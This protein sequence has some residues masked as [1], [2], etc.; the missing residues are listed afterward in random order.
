MNSNI[1]WLVVIPLIGAAVSAIVVRYKLLDRIV[2]FLTFATTLFVLFSVHVGDSY[3]WSFKFL[4]TTLNLTFGVSH[5]SIFMLY[6]S[7]VFGTV[8]TFYSLIDRSKM[9][10][11]LL[12]LILAANN[13]IFMANDMLGFFFAWELMGWSS[14][15]SVLGGRETENSRHSALYYA[16][17]SIAGSYSMLFGIFILWRLTGTF[18]IA[19]NV[20]YLS[21]TLGMHPWW[22]LGI[23]SLFFVTFM[24]K[25]GIFPFHTWVPLAY[26]YSPD[27]FT[28]FLS[29]VMSKYGVYGMLLF[30]PIS[31]M[32]KGFPSAFGGIPWAN[33]TFVWIGVVT[34]VVGTILAIFQDDVKKLLAYSSLSNLGY[35]VAAIAI[36]SPVGVTAG[37]YHA[38]NHLLFKG[39]LF[40][41][42][43]AVISRTGTSKMSEMG[44]LWKKMPITFFTFFIGIASAAGI[45]PFNGFGSKWMIYQAMIKQHLPFAIILLFLASTGA[46]MY[47]FKAFHSVFLGQLSHKYDNVKEVSVIG[48]IVEFFLMFAMIFFGVQPGYILK[49]IG[50]IVSSMGLKPLPVMANG[51]VTGMFSNVYV[52]LIGWSLAISFIFGFILFFVTAKHK[53]VPQENN[54]T[55]GQN[56]QDWGLTPET[57]QFSWNFYQPVEKLFAPFFKIKVDGFFRGVGDWTKATGSAIKEIFV[58]NAQMYTFFAVVGLIIF[59]IAGWVA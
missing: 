59:V 55:A 16:M 7:V 40:I 30:L 33:Y 56:P 36:F 23:V 6:I 50:A 14:V 10:G 8:L 13:W 34:A 47:L 29:G 44:G 27:S 38:F 45:P 3:L 4:G 31:L 17:M 35:V 53:Y 12:L 54:Y 41:T 49:P 32:E 48:Q 57:Y 26:A 25:S 37:I 43:I 1:I 39:A 21:S 2:T 28:P 9:K 18:S 24:I 11:F 22:V 58:E 5:L 15:L 19:A 20:S 52:P 51:Y 42:L 46:F